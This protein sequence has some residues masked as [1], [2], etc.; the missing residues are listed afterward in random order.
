MP[1]KT[2]LHIFSRPVNLY[3]DYSSDKL[4]YPQPESIQIKDKK[5]S[6]ILYHTMVNP[7]GNVKA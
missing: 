4:S 6:R 7:D 1:T 5:Q 2:T 3:R